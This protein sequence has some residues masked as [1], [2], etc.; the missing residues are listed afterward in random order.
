VTAHQQRS[1]LGLP[2]AL[3]MSS[4]K[5]TEM[6]EFVAVNDSMVLFQPESIKRQALMF[7]R[8]AVTFVKGI[9]NNFAE[10]KSD[11]F[12]PPP[13]VISEFEWLIEQGLVFEPEPQFE[14]KLASDTEFADYVRA[15]NELHGELEESEDLSLEEA[16]RTD[17]N[18][19]IQITDAAKRK[20]ENMLRVMGM[21]ARYFAIQL[22]SVNQMD[23]YPVLSDSMPQYQT[24]FRKGDVVEI[25]VNSLPV[26]DETTPWEH[27]I[28]YR[29]DADS[30]RKY[31]K[32]RTW[33][34]EIAT[35]QLE[36]NRIQEKL[37]DLL[38]DYE[39]HMRL[40]KIKTKMDTLKTVVKT[41]LGLAAGGWFAGLTAAPVLIGMTALPLFYIK[42]RKVALMQEEATAPGKEVAY[43]LKARNTFGR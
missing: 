7:E 22:R 32:L 43:I 14:D 40:Y 11:P 15:A 24:P 2:G 33:M 41:E 35:A 21:N 25:V 6:A 9:V 5:G 28:E 17:E 39:N 13:H 30:L 31:L 16:F 10:R 8:I 1:A 26:P 34:S 37:Q 4:G 27:I 19:N 42:E 20:G 18:G 3:F 12:R 23:A 38:S 36:R 29:S